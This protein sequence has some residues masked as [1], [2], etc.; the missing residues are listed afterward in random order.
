MQQQ[1]VVVIPICDPDFLG[2]KAKRFQQMGD[3]IGLEGFF[4]FFFL[5]LSLDVDCWE[6]Q[7]RS[8]YPGHVVSALRHG[9][10]NGLTDGTAS[11][12]SGNLGIGCSLFLVNH[13]NH[14]C[15]LSDGLM[16]MPSAPEF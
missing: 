5:L 6:P 12:F 2:A 11:R 3:M 10:S 7:I 4:P 15:L 1:L 16:A 13:R 14:N 9:N 8:C